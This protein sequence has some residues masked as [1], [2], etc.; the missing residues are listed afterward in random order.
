MKKGD[1]IRTCITLDTLPSCMNGYR[2]IKGESPIG[3]EWLKA[4]FLLTHTQMH[5]MGLD[6]LPTLYR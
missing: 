3:V 2:V 5:R 4:I 1:S 6:Y